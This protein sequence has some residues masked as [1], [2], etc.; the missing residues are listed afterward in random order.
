MSR[1]VTREL[2]KEHLKGYRLGWE[3]LKRGYGS[4]F[5]NEDMVAAADN[6]MQ[7][8]KNLDDSERKGTLSFIANFLGFG[9]R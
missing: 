2:F 1:L 4:T 3:R 6:F 9:R 7:T 5:G 8:N